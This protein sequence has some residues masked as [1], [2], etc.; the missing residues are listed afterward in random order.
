MNNA[1]IWCV[2]RP[3]VGMPLFLAGVGITSLVVHTAV[4]TNVNWFGQFFNGQ[5]LTSAEAVLPNGESMKSQAVV[6]FNGDV[7]DGKHTAIVEL[8][9]G[10]LAKVT[11]DKAAPAVAPATE[12]A[13]V[14]T[15]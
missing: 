10:R 1:R 12:M 8:E 14:K 2:V 6:H 7:V 9:D 11:F 13:A 4:L 3:T 15:E 5:T